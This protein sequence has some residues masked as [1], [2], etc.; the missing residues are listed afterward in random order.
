MAS[1]FRRNTTQG[2]SSDKRRLITDDQVRLFTSMVSHGV[3]VSGVVNGSGGLMIDG[4]VHQSNIETSDHSAIAIS[5][6]GSV[7]SSVIRAVDLLIEGTASAV[8]ITATRKIEFGPNS[9][10]VG[11]LYKG[12]NAE[13]Y[14]A[15]TA[16][17]Q[18]LTIKPLQ[19]S[20]RIQIPE[21]HPAGLLKDGH[22]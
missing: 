18:D 9:V 20:V 2:T 3:R 11:T 8:V 13:M 7:V 4:E 6:R 12:P 15:P 19:E 16:D 1:W 14:V 21:G 22:G 10:V 17:I 5:V